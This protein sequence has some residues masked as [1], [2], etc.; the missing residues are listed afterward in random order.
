MD[1]RF[2]RRRVAPMGT[3]RRYSERRGETALPKGSRA[4]A[5]RPLPAVRPGSWSLSAARP[6]SNVRTAHSDYPYRRPWRGFSLAVGSLGVRCAAGT[7]AFTGRRRASLIA[8]TAP[9]SLRARRGQRRRRSQATHT[10]CRTSV[11]APKPAPAA[12]LRTGDSDRQSSLF[13]HSFSPG[14]GAGWF[15]GRRPRVGGTPLAAWRVDG[16]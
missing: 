16:A 6:P 12:E 10:R 3:S 14:V 7:P 4:A 1:E 9:G 8:C 2:V 5:A 15:G 13:S 11:A